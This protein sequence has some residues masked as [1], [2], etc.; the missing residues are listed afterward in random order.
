MIHNIF[1]ELLDILTFVNKIW[2]DISP[3]KTYRLMQANLEKLLNVCGPN[4]IK[5]DK[6]CSDIFVCPYCLVAIIE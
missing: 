2:D 1:P 4:F 5:V 3:D 6:N